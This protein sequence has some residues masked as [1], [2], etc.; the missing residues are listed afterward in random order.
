MWVSLDTWL[1]GDGQFPELGLGTVV[2][3]CG[4]RLNSSY[5]NASDR[6]P[7]E[8]REV[9]VDDVGRVRYEVTGRCQS[10][11]SP[12]AVLVALPG[13]LTIAEPDACR[14]VESALDSPAFEPWSEQFRPPA[15]AEM[16]KRRRLAGSRR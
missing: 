4:L 16:L 10:V 3:D 12:M 15:P 1:I 11:T 7:E 2:R 14:A 9:H 8:V 5:L 6:S 13:W